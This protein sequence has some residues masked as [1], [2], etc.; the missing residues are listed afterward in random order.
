VQAAKSITAL[1]AADRAHIQALGRPAGSRLRVH[2][3][4]QQTPV[5]SIAGVARLTQ[6]TVSTV[7]AS[8]QRLVTLGLVRE[9]TGRRCGRVLACDAY[10]RMLNEGTEPLP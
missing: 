7:T 10:L 5:V 1:F 6:L 3:A 8:F 2:H 4:L 9:V